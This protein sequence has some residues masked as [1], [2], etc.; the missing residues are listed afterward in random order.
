MTWRRKVF[1]FRA[2]RPMKEVCHGE[3][4]YLYNLN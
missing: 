2:M 3:E 1:I 4:T